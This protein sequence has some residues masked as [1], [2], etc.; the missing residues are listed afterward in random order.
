MPLFLFILG[1][2]KVGEARVNL[3]DRKLIGNRADVKFFACR[4]VHDNVFAWEGF[5]ENPHT[6]FGRLK[7]LPRLNP[8]ET[9]VR[10]LL[11]NIERC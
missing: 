7:V 9:A 8:R 6:R 10:L 2:V 3:L 11:I 4:I 5:G 1:K